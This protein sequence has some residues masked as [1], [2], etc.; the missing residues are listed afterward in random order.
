MDFAFLTYNE[1][2]VPLVKRAEAD[3]AVWRLCQMLE[4]GDLQ[5]QQTFFIFDF[6]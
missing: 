5:F 6:I 3:T 2:V 1:F 4:N